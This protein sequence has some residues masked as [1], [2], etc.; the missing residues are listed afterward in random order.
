MVRNFAIE[1]LKAAAIIVALPLGLGAVAEVVVMA[2]SDRDVNGA[3]AS[4]LA[5][6]GAG[7]FGL[8][9]AIVIVLGRI[10][11]LRDST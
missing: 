11:T 4:G 3:F 2:I 7:I 9:V 6:I 10:R 5:G 8:V 1:F